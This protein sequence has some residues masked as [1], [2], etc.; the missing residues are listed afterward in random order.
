MIN[1]IN[2]IDLSLVK[3]IMRFDYKLLDALSAVM[4]QQ[5]FEQAA[6][7]LFITQSAVSQ[8]I[9]SLEESVGQPVI[10][11]S[12]P[13]TV[14][15]AG[16]KLLSHYKM[17][18]QLEN[19]LV[20][21]LLPEVPTN[22]VK[23][24]L[25]VNAD[26][27]ATWFLDAIAPV[28]KENLVE[29]D[30]IVKNE[31]K[32]IEKLRSGEAVGAVTSLS[33]PLAGY[34]SF[35]LGQLEF[36]LVASPEF[37]QRYFANGLTKQALR[38]APG[39]SYDPNDDMHV[40]FIYQ[41]FQIESRDYY[42]HSVRSS[43]AFVDLAKKGVAYCLISTLQIKDELEKGE[44]INLCPDK[45]LVEKLYWHSWVLVRGINKKLSKQ[46]VR[47]GQSVLAGN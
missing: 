35:E 44:L 37:K 21:E 41:H 27:I 8:R 10:V 1:K 33:K 46:I 12:Q 3:L 43:Q 24:A 25:A 23:I 13:I 45:T 31:S 16:E 34:Q 32:T 2:N 4:E 39:I 36:I 38:Q 26:S 18:Q 22:P 28:L 9:K 47:Y 6:A 14:T 40:R 30:L 29:L 11:R 42:C 7:K 20:P 17:V 19:E 5:S 15:A